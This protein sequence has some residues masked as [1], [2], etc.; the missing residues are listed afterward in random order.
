MHRH[1]SQ[2]KQ[3]Q[4]S[5]STSRPF[6]P[7]DK[8]QDD[9]RFACVLRQPSEPPHARLLHARY[10]VELKDLRVL[11]ED[12][13]RLKTIENIVHMYWLSK[14]EGTGRL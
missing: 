4:G 11:D 9:R 12:Y 8:L 13:T 7:S 14:R 5:R 1:F 2:P 6:H 3:L 10:V